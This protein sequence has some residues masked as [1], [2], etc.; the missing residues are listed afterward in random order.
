MNAIEATE[1][2]KQYGDVTA[3]D[4]V[5]LQVESGVT[6]GLLG[7]N[8]AGKTTLFKLLI[9]HLAPD[10]GRLS[11]AGCDVERAGRSV[12]RDVGYLP[13]HAGF[14]D[15]LTGREVL[16]YHARMR[17]LGDR[18]GRIETVLDRVGLAADADR[19]TA[20]YSKGM[21]RRL[22]LATALLPKP[23]ILLLDEPTAGLDPLGI[24]DLHRVVDDLRA[25]SGLTV[26][27]S[28]HVMAEV[29]TLCDRAALL[30]DGEVIAAG[31]V[32]DLVGRFGGTVTVRVWLDSPDQ[33]ETVVAI[34]RDHECD[35]AAVHEGRVDV[36]CPTGAAPAL[37]SALVDE[38]DL[39]GYEVREP[40]LTRVFENAVAEGP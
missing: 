11:V 17:G 4:G 24:A 7:T 28:S 2:C 40:G 37:L 9:G 27:L 13:E 6:F 22:G 31:S 29:E 30:H 34:A 14:P 3:L 16:R 23:S 19:R 26:V 21:G 20:G 25:E 36:D 33:R 39:D 32:G 5:D 15:H 35:P 38:I 1:V 18:T 10:G 12:R 8:G